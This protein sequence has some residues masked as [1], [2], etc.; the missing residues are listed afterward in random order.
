MEKIKVEGN[1]IQ[2][3]K[4]VKLP[5]VTVDEHLTF[6]HHV[7]LC[8]KK[9]MQRIFW[10]RV[11][12]R[13]GG[14]SE[15]LTRLYRSCIRSIFEYASPVWF[16]HISKLSQVTIER[17]EKCALRAIHP[18]ASYDEALKLSTI[19]PILKHLDNMVQTQFQKM[20]KPQHPLH[21]LIPEDQ[22]VVSTRLTRSSN[23]IRVPQ[24]RLKLRRNS[25]VMYAARLH[26]KC[27]FFYVDFMLTLFCCTYR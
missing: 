14:D 16:P 22:G 3:V 15:G 24:C 23:K 12:K 10:L 9:A 26:N 19:P 18:S 4:F 17:M 1:S 6:H 21:H 25:F 27:F 20:L 5:G 7:E 2:Q 13:H 11:L 8:K